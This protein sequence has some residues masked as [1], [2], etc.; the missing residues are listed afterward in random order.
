MQTI[1]QLTR[2]ELFL[3]GFS[4]TRDSY[5]TFEVFELPIL[6][7]WELMEH[8]AGMTNHRLIRNEALEI[9]HKGD[10]KIAES[11]STLQQSGCRGKVM[12]YGS[13]EA[14]EEEC[15]D[16]STWLEFDVVTGPTGISGGAEKRIDVNFVYHRAAGEFDGRR[17]SQNVILPHTGSVVVFSWKEGK[18]L[19]FLF[20]SGSVRAANQS[21]VYVEERLSRESSEV[22]L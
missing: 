1:P 5:I 20:L 22:E 9:I 14:S 21:P 6:T 11:L 19:Q 12:R 17:V 10:G 8:A 15:P 16:D 3:A 4:G 13:R 7:E 18:F 2:L